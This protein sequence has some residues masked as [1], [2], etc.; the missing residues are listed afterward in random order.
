MNEMIILRHA[1]TRSNQLG[2]LQGQQDPDG[3]LLGSTIKKVIR[4]GKFLT[5]NRDLS[6]YPLYTSPLRRCILTL[7]ILKD[8][9]KF[10]SIGTLLGLKERYYGKWEGKNWSEI[11]KS[12]SWKIYN[13]MK[14]YYR[15]GGGE[16]YH[17]LIKRTDCTLDNILCLAWNY[18]AE[19][20]CI[21][22][23]HQ[24]INA[25]LISLLFDLSYKE[26]YRM[27]NYDVVIVKDVLSGSKAQ[28][29]YVAKETEGY[30]HR[31]LI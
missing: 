2:I 14:Y 9:L 16:S 18:I 31:R 11:K 26:S 27:D 25:I 24:T 12:F 20:G 5:E 8:F 6:K 3:F 22:M 19:S 4:L 23:A 10:R 28:R 13:K 21:I 15:P 29:L 7:D 1:E 30:I 17:D